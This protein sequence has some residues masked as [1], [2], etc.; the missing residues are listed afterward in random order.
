MRRI[1]AI[2]GTTALLAASAAPAV[3]G[4]SKHAICHYTQ[5]GHYQF[6]SIS[7]NAIKENGHL[8]HQDGRDIVPP[9]EHEGVTIF[10][11]QN[12]DERGQ[13]LFNA[14]CEVGDLPEVGA[15]ENLLLGLVG[16]LTLVAG[17]LVLARRRAA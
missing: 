3:A 1:A 5:S 11:G 9:F 8:E 14:K 10:A 7:W 16:G 12:W 2:A 17:G 13:A 15:Q 4:N 6:I